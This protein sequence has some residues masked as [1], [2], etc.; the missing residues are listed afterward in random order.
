MDLGVICRQKHIHLSNN[1]DRPK[2]S[3]NESAHRL[4]QEK[5]HTALAGHVSKRKLFG[6]L[7]KSEVIE[8]RVRDSRM[9]GI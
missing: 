9:L 7:H 1:I 5:H 3:F 6:H 4:L 2:I 8:H